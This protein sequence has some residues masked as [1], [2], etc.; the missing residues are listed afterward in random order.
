[1]VMV[2]RWCC[3][4]W[5]ERGAQCQLPAKAHCTRARWIQHQVSQ[6]RQIGEGLHEVMLSP[7]QSCYNLSLWGGE[8]MSG[9]DCAER[10]GPVGQ[11]P[12]KVCS[13][14]ERYK[15]QLCSLFVT[16]DP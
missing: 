16:Q 9:Q 15:A 3:C 10:Y 1:M 6:T 8:A 11:W 2:S 4:R 13:K 5:R 7:K 14:M 12:N